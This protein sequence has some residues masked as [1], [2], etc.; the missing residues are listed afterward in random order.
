MFSPC[1]EPRRR[2][3]G[4]GDQE[5]LIS[6]T[7]RRP[8]RRSEDVD[9]PIAA[10]G[11]LFCFLVAPLSFSLPFFNSRKFGRSSSICRR[12][13]R[14]RLLMRRKEKRTTKKGSISHSTTDQVIVMLVYR[15]GD[16]LLVPSLLCL[17]HS[18]TD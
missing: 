15:T 4:K 1:P 9:V 6:A 12:H 3:S 17:C 14:L 13:R 11:C 18:G 2:R 16:S 7:R 5:P 8:R 10:G